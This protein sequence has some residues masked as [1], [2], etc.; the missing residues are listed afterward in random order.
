MTGYS[1]T[2]KRLPMCCSALP[3]RFVGRRTLSMGPWEGQLQEACW[4]CEV[5][6]CL[7]FEEIFIGC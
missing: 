1:K 2:E 7:V 4:D 6:L 3:K 5:S